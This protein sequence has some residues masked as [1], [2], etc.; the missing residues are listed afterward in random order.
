MTV[1]VLVKVFDGIVLATDSATTLPLADGSAQVY[2]NADKVFNLHRELPIA[3]MTWGLG[4]VGPASVSTVAKDLRERL[5][6]QAGPDYAD[7][8]VDKDTYT[9]KG[10]AE[11]LSEMFHEQL[12]PLAPGLTDKCLGMIVAGYSAGVSQPE[13]WLLYLDGKGNDAP[14]PTLEAGPDDGGYKT[15]AQPRAAERLFE[16]FD[17]RLLAAVKAAVPNGHHAAIEAALASQRLDPVIPPMPFPD[18]IAFAKYL[19][20]VT[21]GFTHFLLGPDTVGGPIEIAGIN[22]HEGFKWIARKHYYTPELN[23]GVNH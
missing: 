13:A 3:A 10:V 18:A 9:I 12:R 20:E 19:V 5:M 2:N 16:G 14:V 4:Q 22:R 8:D 6:G 23:V 17:G 7:W 11:R 15:Y 1:A 21:A